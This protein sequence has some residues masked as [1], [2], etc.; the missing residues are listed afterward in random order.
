MRTK[1]YVSGPLSLGDKQ[2]NVQNA[3][4]AGKALLVLGYAPFIPHLTWYADPHDELGWENWIESDLAWV[5]SC[6]VVLR[7]PGESKG[8]D[9]ECRHAVE[10]G[11]PVVHSILAIPS[12][13]R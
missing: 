4:E 9:L 5:S 7:L 10:L 1:V 13:L 8:A 11:I 3:I 2:Q 6:A 12:V